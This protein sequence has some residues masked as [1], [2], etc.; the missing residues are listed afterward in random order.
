FPPRCCQ[1][2]INLEL[3]RSLLPASKLYF[4]ELKVNRL[5]DPNLTDCSQCTSYVGL[6][7]TIRD[8]AVYPCCDAKTCVACRASRTLR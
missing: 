3:R 1:G 2:T 8:T 5:S 7:D 6:E 4:S